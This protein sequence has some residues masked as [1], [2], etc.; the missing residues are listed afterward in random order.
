MTSETPLRSI[1][2]IGSGTMGWGVFHSF[3]RPPFA[4]LMLSRNP[5]RLPPL[6]AGTRAC[7]DLPA[8]APDLIIE[9]IPEKLELKAEL[10]RRIGQA[11]GAV[12]I[13][14]SNTSGLPLEDL[15]KAYGHPRQFLGMHYFQPA[16]A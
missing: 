1:M 11:Y 6:P 8:T 3:A 15:A 7:R 4:T 2:V 14:T 13:V 5:D 12:P 9:C 10:F 16:E